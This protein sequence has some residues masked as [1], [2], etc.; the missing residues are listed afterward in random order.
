LIKNHQCFYG[1][2]INKA[3]MFNSGTTKLVRTL[4]N[5]IRKSLSVVFYSI[6]F[7]LLSFLFGHEMYVIF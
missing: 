5:I 3:N 4:K 1:G 2:V 6:F 7:M